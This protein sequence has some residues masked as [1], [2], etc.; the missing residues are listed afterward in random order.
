MGKSVLA[1]SMAIDG[2]EV[3]SGL[4]IRIADT[5]QAMADLVVRALRER[6]FLPR[7][8]AVN[9]DFVEMRYSWNKHLERLDALLDAL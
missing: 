8:S 7:Y 5:P 9:R 3:P 4:D 2:L 1:T 6:D